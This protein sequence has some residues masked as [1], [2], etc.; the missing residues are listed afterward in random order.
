MG[1]PRSQAR[2]L[3]S[4]VSHAVL[5][6]L[7]SSRRR[8]RFP[9]F[10]LDGCSP[11]ASECTLLSTPA[12]TSRARVS[13][14]SMQRP[15]SSGVVTAGRMSPT[16]SAA[17]MRHVQPIRP[18]PTTGDRSRWYAA[19]SYRRHERSQT[20]SERLTLKAF[21][22]SRNLCE[23]KMEALVRKRTDGNARRRYTFECIHPYSF[24][25]SRLGGH[26]RASRCSYSSE[27]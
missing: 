6:R 18:D 21:N 2:V 5:P 25:L 1:R 19:P 17:R 26:E 14:H 8:R 27:D 16:W 12:D 20:D 7:V 13:R 9:P 11:T 10:T 4:R 23:K 24:T 22:K 15:P 3:V